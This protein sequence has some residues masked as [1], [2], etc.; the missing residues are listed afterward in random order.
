M[1]KA[2]PK[3]Q[4]HG[5]TMVVVKMLVKSLLGCWCCIRKQQLILCL[6]LIR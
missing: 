1:L 6:M 5:Y 3:P 2:V 4:L